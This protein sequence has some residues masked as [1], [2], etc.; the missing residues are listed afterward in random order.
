MKLLIKYK[1][2]VNVADNVRALEW[3]TF[4]PHRITLFQ[5]FLDIV[6]AISLRKAGLHCML[7]YKADVE[8]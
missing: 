8:I 7:L 4:I 1:V 6:I 3:L 5:A 2:D